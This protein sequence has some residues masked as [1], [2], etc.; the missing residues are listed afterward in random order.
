[1]PWPVT[2]VFLAVAYFLLWAHATAID[3]HSKRLK[4]I[5]QTISTR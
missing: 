4:Q 3:S 1:M 5:E 2:V